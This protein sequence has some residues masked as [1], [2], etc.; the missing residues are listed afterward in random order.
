MSNF[1]SFAASVA[2][3][4]HGEKSHT[5]SLTQSLT[6]PAYLIARVPKLALQKKDHQAD[7]SV[8][9]Q[10][11]IQR[12][13]KS[14]LTCYH[15]RVRDVTWVSKTSSIDGKDTEQVPRLWVQSKQTDWRCRLWCQ[16]F[17][18]SL[19]LRICTCHRNYTVLVLTNKSTHSSS[20]CPRKWP[21]QSLL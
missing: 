10:R 5:Q 8:V 17:R 16:H 19:P 20:Q 21:C 4:A 11:D 14:V 15:Q 3:L 13:N 12:D 7:Y 2:E 1:I 6:H 9:G 18:Y